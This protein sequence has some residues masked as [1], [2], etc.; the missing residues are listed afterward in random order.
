MS[1]IYGNTYF[2]TKS[3]NYSTVTA[4]LCK[5]RLDVGSMTV[6]CTVIGTVV[7][8]SKE[9]SLPFSLSLL[10][11]SFAVS[12]SSYLDKYMKPFSGFLD[13]SVLILLGL[14]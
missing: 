11:F 12:W 7:T 1:G 9:C 10:L 14:K 3:L 5:L 2:L 13:Y 4:V 6:L 8:S